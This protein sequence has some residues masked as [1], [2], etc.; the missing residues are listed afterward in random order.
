MA[1]Y[2]SLQN[3]AYDYLRDM[4][5]SRELEF[6]KIYS[7]TR[8]AT[9][10]SISRTPI[11]DALNR[12]ARERYIDILPNRGFMLH[13]PNAADVKEA[14]HIRMMIENYCASL[15][16]KDYKKK[17]AREI[18][19]R[20]QQ[21]L[22]EQC[23]LLDSQEAPDLRQFWIEDQRFHYALLDY[24]NISAFNIQYDSFLHI[25]MPQHLGSDV[26]VGRNHSTIPEHR[27]IIKA[28]SEGDEEKVGI[29]IRKHL[30]TS[31]KLMM[32]SP[33]MNCDEE[34]VR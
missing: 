11:R 23:K 12:L 13:K 17:A 25:F 4:I 8:L 19:A 16:A 1:E 2:K 34:V 10:L 15:I 33:D 26:V 31:L 20:M 21:A 30:N 6:D 28:L 32:I 3:V 29:A 18:V 5:Y 22:D 24:L 7:E 27:A 9:Q 14:Y